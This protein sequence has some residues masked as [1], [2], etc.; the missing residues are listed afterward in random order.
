[1]SAAGRFQL[2]LLALIG[3][4]GV[5]SAQLSQLSQQTPPA[6]QDGKVRVFVYRDMGVTSK[7]FR[8]SIFV[9]EMDVARLQSGRSVILALSP[10]THTFRSTDKKDQVQLDLK[11][12]ERYYVRIDVS[13]IAVKGRG[14]PTV[15]LPEQGATEYAQTKPA[16][17][18]MVKAMSLIAPEFMAK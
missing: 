14:K 10:G 15:V 16:D 11:P 2:A 5:A 1:M 8:P 9:D 7:E 17:R 3:T 12:G 18:T 4:A 6:A 13:T